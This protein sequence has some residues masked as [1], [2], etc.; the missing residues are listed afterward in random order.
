MEPTPGRSAHLPGNMPLGGVS[1]ARLITYQTVSPK[2]LSYFGLE[3]SL[4]G[5]MQHKST[6]RAVKKPRRCCT[7]GSQFFFF[8]QRCTVIVI[9]RHVQ[10]L[11]INS[12]TPAIL[13]LLPRL[14]LRGPIRRTE[15]APW[16]GYPVCTDLR[17]PGSRSKTRLQLLCHHSLSMSGSLSIRPIWTDPCPPA[18]G[19]EPGGFDRTKLRLRMRSLCIPNIAGRT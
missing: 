9:W 14:C 13:G 1:G 5:I 6:E 7:K 11:R 2:L 10:C 4:Q 17:S 3:S 19:R 15:L 16:L 18:P 8:W 12:R